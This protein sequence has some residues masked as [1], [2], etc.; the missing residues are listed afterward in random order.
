MS[1]MATIR[2]LASVKWNAP[3]GSQPGAQTAPTAPS[4]NA[5]RAPRA[6]PQ[7]CPATA[8]APS[9]AA[10]AGDHAAL[11]D[12]PTR[13]AGQHLGR[14]GAALDEGGDFGVGQ[15]EDVVQHECEPFGGRERVEHHQQREADRLTEHRL[16]CGIS[17]GCRRLDCVQY[18][19][20]ERF[21]T[22]RA[23]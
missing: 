5:S 10:G 12:S 8:A 9:R 6:R 4:I 23:P 19:P 17:P 7:N 11:L 18:R 14:D 1:S 15:R 22:P 16:V 2:P 3:A 20:R 13:A 21:L